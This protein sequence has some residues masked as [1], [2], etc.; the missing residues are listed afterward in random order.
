[1]RFSATGSRWNVDSKQE[2]S[3]HGRVISPDGS[4]RLLGPEAFHERVVAK[5]VA[6][7]TLWER[8]GPADSFQLKEYFVAIGG[9][10]PGSIVDVQ[11]EVDNYGV[12]FDQTEPLQFLNIPARKIRYFQKAPPDDDNFHSDDFFYKI[13]AFAILNP[14]GATLVEDRRHHTY[15]V[16]ASN[17]PALIDEPFS[18]PASY[19]SLSLVN[20]ND[21]YRNYFH[22]AWS[23]IRLRKRAEEITAGSKDNL[24]KASRIHY[25]V[26]SL[27]MRFPPSDGAYFADSTRAEAN[28]L[29]DPAKIDPRLLSD[30]LFLAFAAA[31]YESVGFGVEPLMMHDRTVSIMDK[32]TSTPQTL[33]GRCV[34]VQVDGLWHFSAPQTGIPIEFDCVPPEFENQD[35]LIIPSYHSSNLEYHKSSEASYLFVPAKS[36]DFSGSLNRAAFDLSEEGSL[37]GRFE[38][39][40][41]GHK[42]YL[43]RKTLISETVP[44]RARLVIENLQHDLGS[45]GITISGISNIDNAEKPLVIE[46]TIRMDSYSTQNGDG[47][48]LRPFVFEAGLTSP[49]P[50]ET[51]R[52]DLYFP[53][54]YHDTDRIVVRLPRTLVLRNPRTQTFF[55]ERSCPS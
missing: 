52:Y 4:V 45:A 46:G 44:E 12:I 43:M 3:L 7:S 33:P 38:I 39:S 23:S 30:N 35:A 53:F 48:I 54:E 10:Q 31:L 19:K 6:G 29:L 17:L 22:S 27:R 42:A 1:M 20:I 16:E 51:R 14:Q 2:I 28:D 37:S 36:A 24:D 13:H 41:R 18:G 32:K 8:L 34:A 26:Q 21:F 11:I 25:Y 40:L 50:S 55:L 49:F 9:L 5:Q 15:T 47:L